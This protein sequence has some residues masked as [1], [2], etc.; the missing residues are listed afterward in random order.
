ME[1]PSLQDELKR[2][3]V[4]MEERGADLIFDC[5][6]LSKQILARHIPIQLNTRMYFMQRYSRTMYYA[7]FANMNF[8]LARMRG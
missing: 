1:Y 2:A 5:T 7:L 4:F 6:E 3:G 8:W